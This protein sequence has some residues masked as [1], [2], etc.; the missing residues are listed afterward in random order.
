M[1]RSPPARRI[2]KDGLIYELSPVSAHQFEI[3]RLRAEAVEACHPPATRRGERMSPAQITLLQRIIACPV[4]LHWSGMLWRRS[5]QAAGLAYAPGLNSASMRCLW[6]KG[7]IESAPGKTPELIRATQ[8]A[9]QYEMPGRVAYER[10]RWRAVIELDAEL[11]VAW[12][13]YR[14]AERVVYQASKAG[15]SYVKHGLEPPPVQ[16]K[17]QDIQA[18][19]RVIRDRERPPDPT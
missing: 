12:D 1:T 8:R 10:L 11:R 7:I 19:M 6:Q 2:V 18:R 14:A 16:A 4:P 9:G 5:G 17:V 13:A 3:A 15:Q